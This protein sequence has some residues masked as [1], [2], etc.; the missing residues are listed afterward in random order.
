MSDMSRDG[1]PIP[2]DTE[3][4]LPDD[5][6]GHFAALPETGQAPDADDTEGHFRAP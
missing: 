3:G 2:V 4:H 6:E 1:L 5:T